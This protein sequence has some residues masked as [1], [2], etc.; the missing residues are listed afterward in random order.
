MF[1]L[2]WTNLR[3]RLLRTLVAL[4]SITV[5]IW[6]AMMLR[7]V[8]QGTLA[9]SLD[10]LRNLDRFMMVRTPGP[11]FRLSQGF[12]ENEPD[13][14]KNV[15]AVPGV[16]TVV[17]FR[18]F[19][20]EFTPDLLGV[21]AAFP[22]D[23]A[24]EANELFTVIEGSQID[25]PNQAIVEFG[26][27]DLLKLEIGKDFTL[28]GMG[29]YKVKGFF[30]GKTNVATAQ[31]ILDLET[32]SKALNDTR[33]QGMFITVHQTSDLDPVKKAIEAR[34]PKLVAE[35]LTF[36]AE[37]LGTAL[38]R[39]DQLINLIFWMSV[40]VA[41]LIC[42]LVLLSM[43]SEQ[44]RDIGILKA[45]GASD[46][47]VLTLI[48]GQAVILGLTGAVMGAFLAWAVKMTIIPHFFPSLHMDLNLRWFME[49][50]VSGVGA[51]T[52]GALG[53]TW[54]ALQVDPVEVLTYE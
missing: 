45:M 29:T 15:A 23:H 40:T 37:T 35:P 42:G 2:A 43:V 21:A 17:P 10:E 14:V 27:A 47:A 30:R 46:N 54:Y 25:G 38:N 7:G 19:I 20:Q 11:I 51:G 48:L 13:L 4:L 28:N 16:D 52:L 5:G 18:F 9:S 49:A 32:V 1:Y 22:V 44:R 33:I 24:K 36:L 50:L 3:Q 39:F 12:I 34:Y 8:S 26:L 41:A 53:A 6:L 31:L